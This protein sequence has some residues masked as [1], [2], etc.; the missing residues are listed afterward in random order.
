MKR[1][2]V[3]VVVLLSVVVG[4]A[5]P[6]LAEPAGTV[7]APALDPRLG[8]AEGY[9]NVSTMADLGA[10]WE[11]LVLGW[12]QIQPRGPGDF[13]NLGFSLDK[14]KLQGELNRGVR[15]AGLLQFTPAWAQQNPADGQRS[16]PRNLFLPF[17]HPDNYFGRFVYETVKYYAGRINEWIIWNEPEFRETD[18]GAGGSFTWKGTDEEF[19]QLMK[20]GYLAAKKANPSATVSFPGTSYW[21]E[22]NVGRTQFYERILAILARDPDAASNGFYHDVVSLNLYRAPDDVYRVY[23]V[24]KGIQRKFGLDKPVWLTETNAMPSDDRQIPCADR[25]VPSKKFVPT[26][27]EQQA[28]YGVQ[29]LAMAAAAGYQRIEFYQIVDDDSCQQPEAWGL[30]RDDGSRRPVA[31]ALKVAIRSFSGYAQA[32]F[33]PLKRE[34]N[35]FGIS[36]WPDDPGALV[37]NWQVYQVALDRPGNQRVS[38]LWNGDG[39]TSTVRV[40]KNGTSAR[41]VDRR[42]GERALQESQGWWVVDLPGAT[43]SHP[44]DPP[45]YYY[46]GGDPLLVVEEGV[47]PAA[48]VIAPRLG[49]PG[50]VAREFVMSVAEGPVGDT[51]A[52][53]Q[54]AEYRV[55]TFSREDFNDPIT[56]AIARWSRNR[57]PDD[58]QD[59]STLPFDV[60]LPGPIQP[61]DVAAIRF[62][63]TRVPEGDIYWITLEASGGGITKSVEIP[64]VVN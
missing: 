56:L 6:A 26:T 42:G 4:S 63:T 2:V 10:G 22:Q 38:V 48:P 61:G 51:V 14:K 58:V 27:M 23:G 64:L 11:R 20:V 15:V 43:A 33:V 7:P 12:S 25:H 40:K 37:P 44:L 57:F 29:A 9:K 49:L 54:P 47:D 46:I 52:R 18:P 13:S 39:S 8:I 35:P 30:T 16:V 32:R 17:D 53:G 60:A 59:G 31:D 24:F 5:T 45:G 41:L 21:V 3:S 1:R 50:S 55:T 62:E 28:A 19:A 36:V 34:R